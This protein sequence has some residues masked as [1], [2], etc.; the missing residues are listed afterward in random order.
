MG[1]AEINF[2]N[3]S[4]IIRSTIVFYGNEANTDIA[5]HTAASIQNHWN[6]PQ[7]TIILNQ[8]PLRIRFEIAWQAIPNLSPETVWYNTNTQFNFFRIE[9]QAPGDISFVDGIRSNT[10]FFKLANLLQTDTTA[11]H[12]YGHGLGLKHPEPPQLAKGQFPGMMYP[13]G[14][15]CDPQFQYLPEAKTGMPGA[16]L[17]PKYR[18]VYPADLEALQLHKLHYNSENKAVLGE[19][20]SIY[21]P[22]Y[23]P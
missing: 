7:G 20:T 10:G 22:A 4:L 3:G 23:Q 5:Q 14:T 11:A 21:H 2:T 19:F 18:R 13:R 16:T 1:E 15:T 8:T 6:Q 17:D 12:E 9:L